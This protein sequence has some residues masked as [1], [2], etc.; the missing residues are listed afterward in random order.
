MKSCFC[1]QK[2]QAKISVSTELSTEKNTS[3]AF[4]T[5]ITK[6]T[7]LPFRAASIIME[8][9]WRMLGVNSGFA[10]WQI[11][12]PASQEGVKNDQSKKMAAFGCCRPCTHHEQQAR[13]KQ[14]P[15]RASIPVHRGGC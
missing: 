13:A 15:R 12:G 14:S 6:E 10:A 1:T 7:A 11:S 4:L 2:I 3:V 8:E 9:K 5:Q